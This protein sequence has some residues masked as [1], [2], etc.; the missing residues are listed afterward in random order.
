VLLRDGTPDQ[1][2]VAHAQS[3]ALIG[4]HIADQL[5]DRL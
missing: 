2:D 1:E 3:L 5:T 4:E